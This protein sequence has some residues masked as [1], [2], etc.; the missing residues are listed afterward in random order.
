MWCT[1]MYQHCLFSF[2]LHFSLFPSLQL[3]KVLERRLHQFAQRNN[4][5]KSGTAYTCASN[6]P[7]Q[8]I[9]SESD[10]D[11]AQFG[12][13][14]NSPRK[15]V[16]GRME[17]SRDT[18]VALFPFLSDC[19]LRC[20]RAFVIPRRR[21]R[22]RRGKRGPNCPV[23]FLPPSFTTSSLILWFGDKNDLGERRESGGQG[24]FLPSCLP[25]PL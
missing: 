2:I 7:M 8:D 15:R 18:N 3:M 13:V 19:L 5:E 14:R 25:A 4:L 21:L 24:P 10:S 23:F 9:T 17:Y 1:G 22:R 6:M 11:V 20:E 12:G 16:R